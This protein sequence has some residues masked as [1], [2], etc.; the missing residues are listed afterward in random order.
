MYTVGIEVRQR[1]RAATQPGAWQK[2]KRQEG[3]VADDKGC[4]GFPRLQPAPPGDSAAAL[5][6]IWAQL[7]KGKLRKLAAGLR[8]MRAG[9]PKR[10]TAKHRKRDETYL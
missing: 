4:I 7:P 9:E 5:I 1:G 6:C 2:V 10:A 3:A 8:G